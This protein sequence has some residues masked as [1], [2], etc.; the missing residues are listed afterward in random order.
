[1]NKEKIVCKHCEGRGFHEGYKGETIRKI[2]VSKE[3]SL[4]QM[5]RALGFSIAFLSDVEL[6]RRN[7]NKEIIDYIQAL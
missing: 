5:A 2:R 4:R 3:I 1:M 6:G 7:P